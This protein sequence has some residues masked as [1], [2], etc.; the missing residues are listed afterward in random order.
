[1][2]MMRERGVKA[3]IVLTSP[4]YNTSRKCKTD[5][6]LVSNQRKYDEYNDSKGAVEYREWLKEVFNGIDSCLSDNGVIIMNLSYNNDVKANQPN[7]DNLIH[8]L[9]YISENTSFIFVDKLTWKKERALP[10][11]ASPNKLTRITE[12]VYVL[13]RKTE[14]STYKVNKGVAVV[15]ERTGQAYYNSIPNY[16]EARNND[17][18]NSINKAT[19]SVEF[20]TKILDIFA[21]EGFLVYDPFMGTGT[22]AI[23]CLKKG[24]HYIG[25]E[26]SGRQ[27]EYANKRID[28][29]YSGRVERRGRDAYIDGQ[30]SL[31]DIIS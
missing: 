1:M 10:N 15:S 24:L 11:N 23:A 19:Y 12:D 3:D 29:W 25:S 26:I 20:C 16:I 22:T 4:P 18:K 8:T 17:G 13:S 14:V 7:L 30:V 21:M 9:N 6:A 28:A 2:E 31:F 27:C 5:K